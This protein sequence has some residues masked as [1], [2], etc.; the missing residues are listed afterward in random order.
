MYFTL[1]FFHSDSVLDEKVDTKD[2]ASEKTEV[3]QVRV[4]NLLFSAHT[5]T[6]SKGN[7]NSFHNVNKFSESL[8]SFVNIGHSI[9]DS[10]FVT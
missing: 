8:K 4:R 9:A 2:T 6:G 5:N 3:K 1:F 7:L 10:A